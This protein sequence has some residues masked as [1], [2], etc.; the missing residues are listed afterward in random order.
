[1]KIVCYNKDKLK[2]T[3]FSKG[4]F[5]LNK[6]TLLATAL[7]YLE[8]HLDEDVRTEDVAKACFC[9]KSTLEKLFKSVN[10]IAV[11][12]Y[13]M[14]RRMMKAA[15]LLFAQPE[16]SVLEVALQF[17]YSTNESFTRAFKQV[18]NCNPSEFRTKERYTELYPRR[19]LPEETG[20]EFM[21]RLKDT[22]FRVSFNSPVIL[23]FAGACFIVMMLN[24]LTGGWSS[25]LFVTYHSSLTSPLTYLQLLIHVLGHANWE[26]F[27]SNMLYILLLGPLLEEKYGRK[28]ILQ[29]IIITALVTGL[30]NYLFFWNV[31]L[32][33]ASGICFAFIILSS[34]TSFKEGEI[35]LT[36][37]IVAVIF[38]GQQIYQGI[39]LE[40][41]ISNITHIVGGIV[42]GV[43]GYLLNAKG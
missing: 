37:I 42:G 6:M 39:T 27:F 21:N 8:T 11:H 2:R 40:D 14:R 35:P 32:C 19:L 25:N 18:W 38:L 33:G 15:K 16:L 26:H 13:L 10:G 34:F 20:D 30:V 7:D 1:M 5:G 4:G 9:S 22:Q 31:A 3:D 23:G 41:N 29:V 36:F 43:T 17:G 12:D 28:R 24:V